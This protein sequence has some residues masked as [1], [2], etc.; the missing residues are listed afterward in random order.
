LLKDLQWQWKQNS[1]FNKEE[2]NVKINWQHF[3]IV[4]LWGLYGLVWG[5]AS[6]FGLRLST[7]LFWILFICAIAVTI[8]M[9]SRA[10]ARKDPFGLTL[11]KQI[12]FEFG[13]G[14]AAIP[15]MLYY[16]L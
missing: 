14:Y 11:S 4:L 9:F 12:A 15:F 10:T 1:L 5:I 13:F 7:V 6:G 8:L 2:E 3:R 16:A